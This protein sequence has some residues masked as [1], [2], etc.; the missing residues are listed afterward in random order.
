MR[1]VPLRAVAYG[2]H[3]AVH[4]VHNAATVVAF[5]RFKLDAD[6]MAAGAQIVHGICFPFCDWEATK[7]AQQQH[8]V[9]I[10]VLVIRASCKQ[11][12]YFGRIRRHLQQQRV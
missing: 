4:P 2:I 5:P 7:Q 12:S 1:S 10:H 9:F 11:V 8:A 3:K 6:A